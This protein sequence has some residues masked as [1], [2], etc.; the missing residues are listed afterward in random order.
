MLSEQVTD[1]DRK[2]EED[3]SW[4]I[5]EL[6]GVSLGDKRLD[7]RLLDTASKL[8]ERP[9]ASLNAACDDWADAK[10]IYRLFDNEK[11]SAEKILA[12]HYERTRE[13][14]S[15]HPLVLS[16]QDTTYL[17][18]THHPKTQGIGPIGTVQQKIRGMLMHTAMF[19]TVAGLPLGL[20]SQEIWVRDEESKCRDRMVEKRQPI[21]T[22]ESFKWLKALSQTMTLVPN[23]TQVVSIGDSESDIFELFVHAHMLETELLV[24]AIHNRA[25]VAP[26]VGRLMDLL[27]AQDMAGELMVQVPKRPNQSSRQ[28]TVS[29]RF[30][31][32]TFKPAAYLKQRK[33]PQVSMYAILVREEAP[34]AETEPLEWLLLTTVPVDTFEDALTCI[35]WYKQRWQIEVFHKVLKSG[36]QVEKSQLA[37]A[38]RLMRFLTLL[39]IISWRLLWLTHI[40]RHQP[41]APCTSVLADHEW[42]AL[43]AHTHHSAQPP[44]QIPTVADAVLAIAKLGGFLARRH[45]GQP[46]ATVIWRGWQRLQDIADTWLLFNPP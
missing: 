40:H 23:G 36:C 1:L 11:V 16:V 43:F 10:A 2:G 42:R 4:V 17:D 31:P 18:Y 8:A 30:C 19:T 7:R 22:K 21:E 20:A 15:A 45:D 3:D 32:V 27:G 33:L 24:R 29:V 9:T 6:G 44:Q 35:G 26:E 14:L 13:R 34:P 38:E 46:G 28:A 41:D 12:P 39:S 37:T 25:V 5:G